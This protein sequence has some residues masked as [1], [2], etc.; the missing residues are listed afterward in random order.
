M[1]LRKIPDSPPPSQHKELDCEGCGKRF[2]CEASPAGCWCSQVQL[3]EE[4]LTELRARY[5][6][7]LCRECLERYA[8]DATPG[9][10]ERRA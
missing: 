4:A 7:C 8:S 9:T 10:S 1:N 6:R 5:K 3:G 2:P